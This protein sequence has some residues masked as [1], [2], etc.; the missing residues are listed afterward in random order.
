MESVAILT[1]GLFTR[2]ASATSTSDAAALGIAKLA[3]IT[4]LV[5]TLY[6]ALFLY[7]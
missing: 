6:M 1:C 4:I 3:V 7:K 5:N 2:A